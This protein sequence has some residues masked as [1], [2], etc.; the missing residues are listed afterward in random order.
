MTK[1]ERQKRDSETGLVD[2]VDYV[3][4]EDGSIDWRSMVKPEFLFPNRHWF[5]ARN[6][7]IP[8]TI[9]GLQDHQLLIKLG[10]I[11][12]LAKL[13]GYDSVKYE[14]VRCEQDY[15]VV[16]CGINWTPNYE[17]PYRSYYED[18]ANATAFNTSDFAL[19][20]LETI[21]ANRAFVRAVRNFLNIH[22]VGSDEMD[23]SGGKPIQKSEPPQ[24]S[25][26]LTPQVKLRETAEE[27][28]LED[29]A[30]FK[31]RLRTLYKNG[32]YK[33]SED[34]KEWDKYSDIPAKEARKLIA[35][36]KKG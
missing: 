18:I 22:I 8:S 13:R 19:K 32:T 12:E 9:E 36:L 10:G 15:V 33:P 34:P 35:I 21:A 14:V 1:I 30:E 31:S 20:F 29:F 26:P 28:G 7:E 3:F 5:E 4:Q 27:H 24:E 16:K 25:S 17:M 2:G 6:K 23:S 11:K